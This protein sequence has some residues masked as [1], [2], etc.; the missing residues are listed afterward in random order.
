MPNYVVIN[1]PVAA[2]PSSIANNLWT[3]QDIAFPGDAS[4]DGSVDNAQVPIRMI[5]RPGNPGTHVVGVS[6][7]TI[8]GQNYSSTI[9]AIPYPGWN[10]PIIEMFEWT[11]GAASVDGSAAAI[12]L[13][14]EV[15]RVLMYNWNPSLNNNAGGQQQDNNGVT[16]NYVG[17]EV[18]VLAFIDP[19]YYVPNVDT[20]I[21]LDID[22]DALE[23]TLPANNNYFDIICELDG[24]SNCSVDA[25][26]PQALQ[27]YAAPYWTLEVLNTSITP[28]IAKIRATWNNYN[29]AVLGPSSGNM[30]DSIASFDALA[31]WFHITPNQGYSL[32]RHMLSIDPL[33][34]FNN[35]DNG[36]CDDE[37]L[38]LLNIVATYPAMNSYIPNETIAYNNSNYNWSNLIDFG[39]TFGNE[40]NYNLNNDFVTETQNQNNVSGDGLLIT[41]ELDTASGYAFTV[42]KNA[43]VQLEYPEGFSSAWNLCNQYKELWKYEALSA[44][45]LNGGDNDED[46]QGG[47]LGVWNGIWLIDSAS[48]ITEQQAQAGQINN[49]PY[50][51]LGYDWAETVTVD[52]TNSDILLSNNITGSSED[53]LVLGNM[54]DYYC[55]SDF[56]GNTVIVGLRN[57]GAYYPIGELIN[58]YDST[59]NIWIDVFHPKNI[60]IKINGSAILN[61]DSECGNFSADLTED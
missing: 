15:T 49:F 11:S 26:L 51:Q 12:S 34:V 13:P 3:N 48:N 25:I 16:E 17:N 33:R 42:Y 24:D 43:K 18:V 44:I 47:N 1:D 37:D 61:D 55:P 53:K 31:N 8:D 56:E 7:F 10:G 40:Y 5:L 54:P 59:N 6:N 28:N 50:D 9:Q 41:P 20:I 21:K 35:G 38:D 30:G 36:F 27:S 4:G 14:T 22:G 58:T 52:N 45:N 46:S 57:F 29:G 19:N 2:Q 60:R 39:R 23:I 32:S